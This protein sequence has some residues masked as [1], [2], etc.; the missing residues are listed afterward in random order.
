MVGQRGRSQTAIFSG[1]AALAALAA[2]GIIAFAAQVLLV[3]LHGVACHARA[4][5][6]HTRTKNTHA[7]SHT[8]NER[9]EWNDIF[10]RKL[11]CSFCS[12]R[13]KWLKDIERLCGGE[14]G[15]VYMREGEREKITLSKEVI[16]IASNLR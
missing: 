15:R 8:K 11:A 3:C 14:R 2:V 5:K 7:H 10:S 12:T 9:E 4:H 6:A 13:Q 1:I 16:E